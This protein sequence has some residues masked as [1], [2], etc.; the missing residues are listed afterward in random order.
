MSPGKLPRRFLPVALAL[1][2]LAVIVAAALTPNTL[3]AAQAVC[4]YGNC[5]PAS[6]FN[7]LTF[8]L[9]G[10]LVVLIALA[11]LALI[12]AM[13]RRRRRGGGGGTL[14]P[15]PGEMPPWQPGPGGPETTQAPPE[16]PSM[17]PSQTQAEEYASS[18]VSA[19]YAPVPPSPAYPPAPPA[20]PPPPPVVAPPPPPPSTRGRA[21]KP[22]TSAPE[23]QEQE[24]LAAGAGGGAAVGA[25][26]GGGEEPDIDRLMQELD[27]ISD[28]ILKK[29]PRKGNGNPPSDSSRE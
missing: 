7:P 15:P 23:W 3:G 25:A 6:S 12:V 1:A 20:P 4:Q 13:R 9:I 10:V 18:G 22:R 19:T 26:A 27:Q 5:G 2:M 29:T 28:D 11:A 14:G 16:Q 17:P 24:D 8:A 21:T